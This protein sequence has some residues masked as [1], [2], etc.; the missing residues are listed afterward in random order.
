M[1][2]GA[3]HMPPNPR[4]GPRV[5]ILRND[6]TRGWT[7]TRRNGKVQLTSQIYYEKLSSRVFVSGSLAPEL[8]ELETRAAKLLSDVRAHWPAPSQPRNAFGVM[9]AILEESLIHDGLD[10]SSL[11]CNHVFYEKHGDLVSELHSHSIRFSAL[12]PDNLATVAELD[13][14]AREVVDQCT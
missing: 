12:S 7:L 10:A 14:L 6:L 3:C 2:N 5:S 8:G 13:R 9:P 11:T 4:G 1:E